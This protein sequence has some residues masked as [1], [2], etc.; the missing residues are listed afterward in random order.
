[1]ESSKIIS[2]YIEESII[3]L[4]K[5][6]LLSNKIE[7]I[8]SI[9]IDARENGKNVFVCGN[10][11]SGSTASHM[12]CDFDKTASMLGRKRMKTY[13]L[14]DNMPIILA[15]GN[16]QSYNDIFVEQLKNSMKPKDV[17][18]AISSSGNSA[19]VINAAKYAKKIKG[20]VIGFTGFKGGKL[21]PIC[22][23]CIVV[24]SNSMYRIEDIHLMLN[25]ILVSVF[26]NGKDY[27]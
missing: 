27:L 24:P 14:V 5:L 15:I 2:R 9:L 23:E 18:I 13:S 19:N 16:D 8:S 7:K 21:K 3:C 6:K 17:L 20:M 26:R 1:M 22:D 12:H 25:H 4:N 10:G 11:G